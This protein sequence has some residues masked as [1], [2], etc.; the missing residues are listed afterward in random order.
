VAGALAGTRDLVL[1]VGPAGTGK[2]RAVAPAVE[3]L[4]ADGRA[5][6]GVAPSAA[7]AEVLAT[8]AGLASDTLDKLLIEH[9]LDRPPDHRYDLPAG[10]TVVVDEA[11]M[12]STPKLAELA[13]L[14]DLRGWRLAL[15]GDPLQFSAVGRSGMFG[16]L[17]DCYGA[18]ELDRVHRFANEWERDASLR[19]RRG[20]TEVL[21]LYDDHGRIHGGTRRQMEQAVVA[22]WWEAQ[23]RGDSVAMMAPRNEIVVELNRRAQALRAQSGAIDPGGPSVEAG[24]YRLHVGDHV[25]TRHND[26][27]LHTDR[28]LM[29]KNR[30]RWELDAVHPGG[31]LTVSGKTG[32]VRL[33]ADYV[34]EHVE[35]AYAQTSHASQGRTVDRSFL[36]LDGPAD[37]RGVYVPMTRGRRA[38]EAFVVLE[39][40]QTALDVLAQALARDWIDEPAVARRAELQRNTSQSRGRSHGRL[41]EPAELRGLLERRHTITEALSTAES[42]ASRY[43][44]QVA[45][46]TKRHAELV[47][48]LA[49]ATAVRDEA[50]QVVDDHDHPLQRRFHRSELGQAHASLRQA[51]LDI[52]R[53]STQLADL[54]RRLSELRSALRQAEQALRNRPALDREAH[55]IDRELQRDLTTRRAAIAADP[56]ERFADWLGPRPNRGSADLWDDAAAHIDQH[57]SAFG[58]TN[59]RNALGSSIRAWEESALVDSQRGVTNACDRLARNIGKVPVLERGL[60]LGIDL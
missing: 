43:A 48:R 35:L 10:S 44:G 41:L 9:R 29:V 18:I 33:P 28:G 52:E 32:T 53:Q 15:V 60:E 30:D 59:D 34:A 50:M 27:Q 46:A 38:N 54:D 14:A 56:P 55:S 1:V 12:V 37:T 39:G 45:R 42:R 49:A 58:I 51:R 13:E 7:A 4:R 19:L 21:D 36:L 40:E 25:A 11:A 3:Q 23:A 22:A 47:E 20:D 8:D 2:T 24:N 17:I 16:H 57:R 6:F 31:G 5:V 26:R